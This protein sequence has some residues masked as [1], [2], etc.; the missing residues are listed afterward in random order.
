[1][2]ELNLAHRSRFPRAV[3]LWRWL[4]K[5]R[6]KYVFSKTYAAQLKVVTYW[7]VED[8]VD[9]GHTLHHVRN[10]LLSREPARLKTIALLDKPSR[11]EVDMKG[12]LDRL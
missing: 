9:T 11:R 1:V 5:A 2:R 12:R 4:W 7:S 8:I 3:Q 6:G 10:L